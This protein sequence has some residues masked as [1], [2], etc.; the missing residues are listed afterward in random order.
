MKAGKDTAMSDEQIPDAQPEAGEQQRGTLNLRT[1]GAKTSYAN[2]A[3]ITTTPPSTT[4]RHDMT[5][6]MKSS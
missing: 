2:L 1:E 6:P 3:L 4:G 5:S